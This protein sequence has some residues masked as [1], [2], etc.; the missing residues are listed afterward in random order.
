M[1]SAARQ[2]AATGA[3]AAPPEGTESDTAAS[4]ETQV[5]TFIG[6]S[7]SQG[8]SQINAYASGE[9]FGPPPPEATLPPGP[10][11]N[12]RD[13]AISLVV[14]TARIGPLTVPYDDSNGTG[15]HEAAGEF[16]R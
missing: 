10:C 7:P 15:L 14:D 9:P 5:A 13:I 3:C 1:A 8:L 16:G 2:D 12:A 4:T 11:W 6:H